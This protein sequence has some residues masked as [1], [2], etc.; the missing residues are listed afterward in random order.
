M[1]V[2][3]YSDYNLR[4]MRRGTRPL[5]IE[6]IIRRETKTD[7]T[8][9]FQRGPVWTTKQKQLL[10]DTILR[11]LDIPKFY[12]RVLKDSSFEYEVVDG[13]Q[14]LRA[15]WSFVKGEFKV[16]KDADPLGDGT[17]I[18]DC[19]YTDLPENVKDQFNIYQL[20]IVELHDA[21][22]ED[23]E[24]MFL[25]LQNGTTLKAAEKRNALPGKMKY[26]IRKLAQN[27][28]FTVSPYGFMMGETRGG[29]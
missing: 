18:K 1:V 3:Q 24:E 29:V 28:F 20:D 2:F 16:S 23:V 25:R 17:E 11:D 27:D 14:R 9:S 13:Q 15:I 10:M 8:P 4:T 12:L 22:K 21:T 19:S 7:P 6:A 26:F 5:T